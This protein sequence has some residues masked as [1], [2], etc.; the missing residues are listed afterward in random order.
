MVWP[1]IQSEWVWIDLTKEKISFDEYRDGITPFGEIYL[2]GKVTLLGV[3]RHY[4]TDG[5]GDKWF[6]ADRGS[7]APDHSPLGAR[8]RTQNL[9]GSFNQSSDLVPPPE[10]QQAI[11]WEADAVIEVDGIW[12]FFGE[13]VDG[14][15]P[16]KHK[17]ISTENFRVCEV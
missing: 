11:C 13:Q 12:V 10:F 1:Y 5:Y 17:I 8:L 9:S 7:I 3:Y 14:S 4:E 6:Y 16:S 15:L 2:G